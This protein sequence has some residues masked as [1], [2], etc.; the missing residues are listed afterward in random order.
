MLGPA[1]T[2]ETEGLFESRLLSSVWTIKET[3]V[4]PNNSPK[5]LNISNT[6]LGSRETHSNTD[7]NI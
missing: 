6:E 5:C 4:F 2:Q 1:D 3:Y 7:N